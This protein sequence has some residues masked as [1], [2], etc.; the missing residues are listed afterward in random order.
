MRQ[1]EE[2]HV[3]Q[4]HIASHEHVNQLHI[5][6]HDQNHQAANVAQNSQIF[7]NFGDIII[8]T[9]LNFS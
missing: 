2:Q 1:N 8:K 6:S 7:K 5:A 3:S 4:L 9:L